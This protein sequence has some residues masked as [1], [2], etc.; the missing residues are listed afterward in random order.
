MDQVKLSEVQSFV[1]NL[2]NELP[3]DEVVWRTISVPYTKQQLILEIQN[4]TD[5]GL[6]YCSNVFRVARDLIVRRSKNEQN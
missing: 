3:D 1:I 4:R 2:L 5:V 6:S